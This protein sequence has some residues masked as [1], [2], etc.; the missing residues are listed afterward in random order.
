MTCLPEQT[1]A[2][3]HPAY[4]ALGRE[5]RRVHRRKTSGQS[6]EASGDRREAS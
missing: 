3:E 1:D 5:H 6:I 4:A 2:H